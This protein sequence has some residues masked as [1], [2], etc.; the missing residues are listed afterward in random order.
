MQDC[1]FCKI[2]NKEISSDIVYEDDALMCFLDIHPVNPG[3]VL[4]VPK[5]HFANLED[6]PDEYN[7]KLLSSIKKMILIIKQ[8]LGYEAVNLL[9][10]NGTAAG[11]MIPHVHFH[12]I[13]RKTGDGYKHWHGQD[14]EDGQA[15]EIAG[16]IKRAINNE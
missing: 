13:P 16:K 6:L 5:S 4:V 9:L 8:D 10:N 2:I 15:A 1:L 11:Q 3:H 7:S 12:V 14:Y